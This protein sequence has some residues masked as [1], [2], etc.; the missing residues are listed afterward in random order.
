MGVGESWKP[1]VAEGLA[2]LYDAF[3]TVTLASG[4]KIPMVRALLKKDTL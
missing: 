1:F 2:Y 4:V 3:M